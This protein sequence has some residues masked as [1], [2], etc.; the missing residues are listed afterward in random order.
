MM[1]NWKALLTPTA[2]LVALFIAPLRAE[3]P[4]AAISGGEEPAAT[5]VGGGE[6]GRRVSGIDYLSEGQRIKVEGKKFEGSRL[7]AEKIEFVKEDD[8][9]EIEGLIHRLDPLSGRFALGPALVLTSETTR[10]ED[11]HKQPQRLSD[12]AEGVRVKVKAETREGEFIQARSVRIYKESGD[13]DFEIEAPIESFNL[14]DSELRMFSI[15]IKFTPKTRFLNLN[16]LQVGKDFPD[17]SSNRRIRRDDD[18][19]DLSP[20]RI[21]NLVLGGKVGLVY[22]QTRNFDLN[23]NTPDSRDRLA[24]QSQLELSMSLGEYTEAYAKLNFNRSFQ[25][26]NDPTARSRANFGVKEAYLNIRHFLHPSLSL[27]VGRQRFRDKREWLYDDQL[28]AIRLRFKR[29]KL[30]V[31]LSAAKGLF[32]PTGSRSDQFYL[33]GY[34]EYRLPH[35]RRL[36]GYFVKRNDLTRRDED[37][38]WFGLSSRGTVTGRFDYWAEFARMMGRRGNRLLRGYGYDV[39]GSYRLPLAWQPTIAYGYAF[40]SGDNRL[41]DG[42]DGNFRQT[43]LNDNTY[44]IKGLKRYRYYGVLTEPELFNLKV[45]TLD[46]GLRPSDEWSIN[47]VYHTYRQAVA[48]KKLGD[49]Q[50]NLEPRGKDP[51]LG[52]ELDV[53]FALR[54][55]RNVDVNLFIGFFSPGP[56]FQGAT[57]RAFLLRPEFRYYF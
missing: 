48:S 15:Q 10:F 39:G 3:K 36:A 47:F 22:E 43:R 32:G 8:H 9:V 50:L 31:E 38:I 23:A 33:I 34:A 57:P 52:K 26:G 42:V 46:F 19:P 41:S 54:K 2:L 4:P 20:V 56:A 7:V 30:K 13:T 45:H 44:R 49:I 16:S 11:S 37:P 6:K 25:L 35:H 14:I 29:S 55:L 21:G 1:I 12:L 40:G 24:P 27:Q 5:A 28:D 18:E 17:I 51:R 53:I